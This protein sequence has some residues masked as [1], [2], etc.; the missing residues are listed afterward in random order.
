[1]AQ[2]R[3][4]EGALDQALVDKWTDRMTQAGG[5][6]GAAQLAGTGKRTACLEMDTQTRDVEDSKTWTC[7]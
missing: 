4:R 1:M 7:I 2:G 3:G 6:G 5:H